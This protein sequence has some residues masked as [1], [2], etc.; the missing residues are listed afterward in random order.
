MIFL[1]KKTFNFSAAQRIDSVG[2]DFRIKKTIENT[3]SRRE[4][5]QPYFIEF[6]LNSI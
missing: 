3:Q 1:Q 5:I 6:Q 2:F 4:P